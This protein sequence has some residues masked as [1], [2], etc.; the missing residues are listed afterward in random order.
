[1]TAF[2]RLGEVASFD[3]AQ[4]PRR[5][6]EVEAQPFHSRGDELPFRQ[7][8]S[9]LPYDFFVP[10]YRMQRSVSPAKSVDQNVDG[11]KLSPA[12]YD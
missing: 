3:F 9:C 7:T 2:Q 10:N 8:A 5:L 4:K 11:Y 1:M 12:K 6:S